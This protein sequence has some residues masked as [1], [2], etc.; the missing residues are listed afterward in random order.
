VLSDRDSVFQNKGLV[1]GASI[2]FGRKYWMLGTAAVTSASQTGMAPDLSGV[3]Q[4]A[5][6][7]STYMMPLNPKRCTSIKGGKAL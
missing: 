2:S 5:L 1:A 4:N 3:P 7:Q 6:R